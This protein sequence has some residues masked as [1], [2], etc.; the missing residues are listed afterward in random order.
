M[1]FSIESTT[2]SACTVRT[3][4]KG[5]MTQ[6]ELVHVPG[7]LALAVLVGKPE[8]RWH[9]EITRGTDAGKCAMKELSGLAQLPLSNTDGPRVA[10]LVLIE[11][12]RFVHDEV[13]TN[14][15]R[16]LIDA[17]VAFFPR[18]DKMKFLEHVVVAFAEWT[19][20]TTWPDEWEFLPPYSL[21][22]S[23]LERMRSC[24]NAWV[25]SVLGKWTRD[26]GVLPSPVGWALW[27]PLA[28]L[29]ARGIW[30]ADV[31]VKCQ[32]HV[33]HSITAPCGPSDRLLRYFMGLPS[34]LSSGH[35][36]L[37]RTAKA[38]TKKTPYAADI[39]LTTLN[40]SSRL[41]SQRDVQSTFHAVA[42][43]LDME[44][45]GEVAEIL[46]DAKHQGPSRVSLQRYRVRL[47]MVAMLWHRLQ[48]GKSSPRPFR[49]VTFDASPQAGIEYF[50]ASERLVSFTSELHASVVIRRLP[51]VQLGH[52]RFSTSDKVQAHV[53][54]TWLD[55]GPTVDSV[56]TATDMCRQCLTDQ[57][58]EFDICDSPDVTRLCIGGH[59]SSDDGEWLYPNALQVPGMQH[60]LD[61]LLREGVER[62]PWWSAWEREAKNAC[63][64]LHPLS[65]RTYLKRR[66]RD[67][68]SEEDRSLLMTCDK[69]AEWRWE[70]CTTVRTRPNETCS[71]P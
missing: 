45:H 53:H 65:R 18:R 34:E 10:G 2:R 52:G 42:T 33:G 3:A 35:G 20:A 8:G 13:S 19:R 16:L 31:S 58:V 46:R 62:L 7:P 23:V 55:Y 54:Q 37:P 17:S 24:D 63:Q 40:I 66:L 43:K 4:R 1:A 32:R 21:G 71:K 60:I 67:P 47:D 59:G 39:A 44:G 48:H 11:A 28:L 64:V 49:Y 29:M 41:R 14:H 27:S 30:Q 25:E 12:W 36:I 70:K 9:K 51:L 22:S 26:F 69:L 68:N 57:G 38:G 5:R 61:G 56:R 15:G 6:A 50:A